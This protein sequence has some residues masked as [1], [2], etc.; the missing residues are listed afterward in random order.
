[1]DLRDGKTKMEELNNKPEFFTFV[2]E[3]EVHIRIYGMLYI[4]KKFVLL[5]LSIFIFRYFVFHSLMLP[6]FYSILY[7]LT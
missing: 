5:F 6:S 7:F 3:K 2:P 1:M 4:P